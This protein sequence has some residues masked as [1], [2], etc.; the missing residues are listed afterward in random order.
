M[1]SVL[2]CREVGV[3]LVVDVYWL[4]CVLIGWS[5]CPG[6]GCLLCDGWCDVVVCVFGGYGWYG[7]VCFAGV[8]VH[9]SEMYA[10]GCCGM[11]W[12]VWKSCL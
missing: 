9:V 11:C 7:L 3:S 6:N 2:A 8:V 4:C 1:C 5:R 12:L 10:F